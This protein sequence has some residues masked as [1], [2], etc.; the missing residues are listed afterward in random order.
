MPAGGFNIGKDTV[1]DINTRRGVLRAPIRTG[2]KAK[3]ETK[4]VQSDGLDGVCRYAELPCGW[5]GE[6]D[7]DR[8]SPE[9]D[10]YFAN[11]E[12]DY[13]GGIDSDAITITETN[14]EVGGGLSQYR[15]TGVCLKYEDAGERKG[16]ATVKQKVTWKAARRLKVS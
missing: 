4:S 7:F 11:A 1:L 9:L 16:D 10:D 14:S 8:A 6:F 12:A 2:F 13:Y 15:Y 5:S 3:Q